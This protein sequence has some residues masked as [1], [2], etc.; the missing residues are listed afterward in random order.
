M[1]LRCVFFIAPR[2]CLS[3]IASFPSKTISPIFTRRLRLITN[4]TFTTFSS[5]ESFFHAVAHLRI[6]K[7]F[8]PE[9]FSNRLFRTVQDK[10]GQFTA[11]FRFKVSNKS[12]FCPLR[13]PSTFQLYTRGRSFSTTSTFTLSPTGDTSIWISEKTPCPHIFL[14]ELE[15]YSLGN[16]IVSPLTRPVMA[17]MNCGSR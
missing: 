7:P 12:D 2:N 9:I 8:F 5:V 16:M 4:V 10:I 11:L 3:E 17:E 13:I 6:I 1:L 15:M 14:M